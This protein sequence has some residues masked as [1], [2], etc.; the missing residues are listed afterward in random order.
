MEWA[1]SAKR[2]PPGAS[3]ASNDHRPACRESL[4]ACLARLRERW[5]QRR[6]RLAHRQPGRQKNAVIPTKAGIHRALF[7]CRAEEKPQDCRL[8]GNDGDRASVSKKRAT[9]SG[10]A[11]VF[12]PRPLAGEG[13]AKRRER[14]SVTSKM[15][16]PCEPAPLPPSRPSP[17]SRRKESEIQMP[18]PSE[19]RRRALKT[20]AA[21][22]CYARIS[23]MKH[24]EIRLQQA[25]AAIQFTTTPTRQGMRGSMGGF[26]AEG[27]TRDAWR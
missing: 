6:C 8:R 10:A 19:T 20:R 9:Q 1:P 7:R 15:A 13:G 27:E 5:L 2:E 26:T 25:R 12:L 3:A 17:A 11:R 23:C 14:V 22:A 24:D 16:L 18:L 21:R 4:C